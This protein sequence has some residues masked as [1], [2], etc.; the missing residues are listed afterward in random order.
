M[1]TNQY[2]TFRVGE[3]F[4]A[5]DIL[6]IREINRNLDIRPVNLAPSF[7]RGLLNLRG[8][9]VTVMDLGMRIK[10]T[11]IQ[12]SKAS[13]CIILKDSEECS[14]VYSEEQVKELHGEDQ[15]AFLVDEIG[16]MVAISEDGLEDAPASLGGMRSDFIQNVYRQD[17]K[18]FLVL[19]SY[20]LLHSEEVAANV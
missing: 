1:S 7:I 9:I 18:I 2:A 19:N 6:L 10:G 12:L 20:H 5:L 8:Q 16:D 14:S 3:N 4:F 15:N 11:P 17:G 13:R